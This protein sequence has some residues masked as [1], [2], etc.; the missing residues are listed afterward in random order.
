[1]NQEE[2]INPDIVNSIKDILLKRKETLSVGESVTSGLV[3]A[4]LSQATDAL[5]FYQGGITAYN[6]GQKYRHLNIEPIHALS[7]NCVSEKVARDMAVNSCQLFNSDWGI[8]ITG[9]ASPVPEA[10]HEVF[11]WYAVAYRDKIISG[12]KLLPEK[13]HPFRVQLYYMRAVL[14]AV[15]AC[16]QEAKN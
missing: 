4:A 10:G 12:D 14:Q 6:V 16:L 7:C 11:A 15:K 3:Q 5:Q 9:Y 13:D 8:G 2:F 1:M